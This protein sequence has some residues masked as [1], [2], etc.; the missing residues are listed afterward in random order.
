MNPSDV[1]QSPTD[2]NELLTQRLNAQEPVKSSLPDNST[3]TRPIGSTV[4]LSLSSTAKALQPYHKPLQCGWACDLY[5]LLA[6]ASRLPSVV[7]KSVQY[8]F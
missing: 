2:P 5:I 8:L 4:D 7:Y 1:P 3:P 6:A